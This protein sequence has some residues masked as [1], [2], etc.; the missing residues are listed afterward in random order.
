M[1]FFNSVATFGFFC[2]V[3]S[4]SSGVKEIN[5]PDPSSFGSV[6]EFAFFDKV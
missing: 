5:A 2:Q 6:A 4:R 3:K 1:Y